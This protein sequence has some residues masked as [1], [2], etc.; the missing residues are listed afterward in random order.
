MGLFGRKRGRDDGGY[1]DN[2]ALTGVGGYQPTEPLGVDGGSPA[3][4]PPWLAQD[5]TGTGR[6]SRAEPRRIPAAPSSLGR[7]GPSRALWI[8][9]AVIALGGAAANLFGRHHPSTPGASPNR[10]AATH[11]P[12]P[13][14][15]VPAVVPG[16]ASVASRDGK[17]AYDVPPSW[18]PDP[19][20]VRGWDQSATSPG[21]TLSTSAFSG[22]N[23]CGTNDHGGAGVTTVDNGDAGAAAH[24]AIRNLIGS[25]YDPAAKVTYSAAQD[26]TVKLGEIAEPAKIVLADVTQDSTEPCLPQHV[27]VGALALAG[28]GTSVIL[29]AY[30]D[31]TTSKADL[32]R[33]LGSYRGVPAA[34]RSTTTPPATTR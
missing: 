19:D 22:R 10:G 23:Y 11:T 5:S 2:A 16:W 3:G 8:L 20:A 28:S 32:V 31:D 6:E 14:V 33:L 24:E 26:A 34:D 30:T 18:T 9:V 12:A 29:L 1:E 13:R 17:Y 15:G 25:A 21:L 27:T 7:R 4:E